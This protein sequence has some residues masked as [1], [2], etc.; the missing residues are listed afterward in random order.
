MSKQIID[1][2]TKLEIKRER[3]KRKRWNQKR[4]R[5]IKRAKLM[6]VVQVAC[7][8]DVQSDC[9]ITDGPVNKHLVTISKDAVTCD[10]GNTI[11]SHVLAVKMFRKEC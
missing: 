6:K 11:C 3:G 4:N 1:E 5:K 2:Q 10:C 9:Y 8:S 7:Q